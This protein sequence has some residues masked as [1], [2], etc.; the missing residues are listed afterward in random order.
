MTT[1]TTS[2][3]ARATPPPEFRKMFEAELPW[4]LTTLRRLGVPPRD[5][6]DLAQEVFVT[7]HGLLDDYDDSRPVRPWLFTIAYRI[8]RRH[9]ARARHTR[10]V[11]DAADVEAQV[12]D[13]TPLADAR[14]ESEQTKAAVRSALERIELSRRSVLI[15]CDLEGL[16]VPDAAATLG[17]PLNT[18]YSRLRRAREELTA[19]LSKL[20]TRSSS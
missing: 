6:A 20:R 19:T 18:A 8:A 14:I 5:L 12:A 11:S 7:V 3:Q 10:E 15:L 1:A 4:V 17:I 16:S 9:C 2:S 13:A